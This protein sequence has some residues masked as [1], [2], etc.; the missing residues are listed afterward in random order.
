MLEE[1]EQKMVNYTDE[2]SSLVYIILFRMYQNLAPKA[3][4]AVYAVSVT[5]TT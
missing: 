2:K 3:V 5:M 1:H 4:T